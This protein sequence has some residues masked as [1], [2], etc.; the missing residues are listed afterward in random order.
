MDG[1]EVSA[2][3]G[4][5]G[6][7]AA[8]DAAAFAGAD[9]LPA[10]SR[11]TTWIVYVV[12]QASEPTEYDVPVGVP[13]TCAVDGHLVAGHADVVVGRRHWTESDVVVA[14]VCVREPGLDGAVVSPPPPP[15]VPYSTAPMSGSAPQYE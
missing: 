10:A 1:A 8:V 3:G 15:P 4:G 12:P 11:A 7:H 2:G 6:G 5:G 14:A 13:R 9:L